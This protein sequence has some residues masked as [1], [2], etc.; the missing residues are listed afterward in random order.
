MCP[1]N[2]QVCVFAYGQ[3]G[4]GKTYTMQGPEENRGVNF[5]AL[6]DLFKIAAQRTATHAYEIS[7]SLL[8]IYNENVHDCLISVEKVRCSF[9]LFAFPLS[10][11]YFFVCSRRYS[12]FARLFSSSILRS[13]RAPRKSRSTCGAGRKGTSS[14]ASRGATWRRTTTSSPCSRRAKA[15]ARL[16]PTTST[17]TPPARTSSC[18][19][20]S[21]G[22][23]SRPGSRCAASCVRVLTWAT[24]QAR[25]TP[26]RGRPPLSAASP[27]FAHA[28]PTV[29]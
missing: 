3:T 12:L 15:T 27:L 4:A 7:M 22:R 26:A 24:T 5:R 16:F 17:S 13:R 21:T 18:R 14:L 2:S 1:P 23:T 29:T 11:F 10:S 28:A 6:K 9:L 20:R 19:F 8:E 25:R